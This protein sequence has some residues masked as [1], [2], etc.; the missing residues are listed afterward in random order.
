MTTSKAAQSK[1]PLWYVFHDS[2]YGDSNFQVDLVHAQSA[3]EA[4][5][6]AHNRIHGDTAPYEFL[7]YTALASEVVVIESHPPKGSTFTVQR[8]TNRTPTVK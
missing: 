5:K 6:K 1:H 4:V 8:D 3:M 2:G 7:Y